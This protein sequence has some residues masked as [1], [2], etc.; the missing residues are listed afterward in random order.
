MLT[1][2]FGFKSIFYFLFLFFT[3]GIKAGVVSEG[4]PE[5]EAIQFFRILNCRPYTSGSKNTAPFYASGDTSKTGILSDT[6]APIVDRPPI[7]EYDKVLKEAI[8]KQLIC[9]SLRTVLY[10]KKCL[11]RAENDVDKRQVYLSGIK[12]IE[13]LWQ[14]SQA[15]ADLLFLRARKLNNIEYETIVAVDEPANERDGDEKPNKIAIRSGLLNEGEK[16]CSVIGATGVINYTNNF[17]ILEKTPYSDK[18][19]IPF[20]PELPEY[21]VYRIQLGVYKQDLPLVAFGGM[22]PLSAEK[23]LGHELVKYYVGYFSTSKEAKKSLEKVRFYGFT[24]AFLVPYF[25]KK[26][27]S[28]QAAREIEFGGK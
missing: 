3:I 16:E 4:Q 28:I 25:E 20:D 10:S 9:D 6:N 21:L 18:F 23:I 1:Y 19:P 14:K 17:Y 13:E 22:S 2:Y 7:T 26:K 8:M 12:S 24:D 11:L 15:E 5:S 27:I